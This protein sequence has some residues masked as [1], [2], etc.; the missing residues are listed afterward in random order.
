MLGWRCWAAV[1][2]GRGR[3]PI[4]A[5]AVTGGGI[6][7]LYLSV[8]AAFALYNLIPAIAALGFSSLVTLAAAGLA[9]R[10]EARAIAILGILGGFATPIFLAEELPSQEA[11]LAYVLILDV[12]VLALATFRNWRWFTL[13]A[14]IG[15]IILFFFWEEEL[16]PPLV[17][18]QVGITVIFLIFVGATTL[19]HVL[20]RRA[21]RLLDQGLIVLNGMAYLGISYMLM[22]EEYRAWMGGFTLLLALFY[23]LLGYGLLARHREQVQLSLFTLGLALVFLTI[24][25]PVELDGPWVAVGVVGAGGCPY[26][27]IFNPRDAPIALGRR[28]PAGAHHPPGWW[29][30]TLSLTAGCL[31]TWKMTAI[32]GPS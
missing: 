25:I 19:F 28:C 5:Q 10:Y 14:L 32:T 23:G 27:A 21:P 9:L 16:D 3:Y 2:T 26:L 1:S 20:W 15:S 13:L 4:W 31:S 18:A 7:I 22:F 12:G 24:A 8:F 11:L 17:L 6:A 29:S 30:M